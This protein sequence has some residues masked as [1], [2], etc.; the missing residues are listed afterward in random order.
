MAAWAWEGAAWFILL[1]VLAAA[2]AQGNSFSTTPRECVGY[3]SLLGLA[4]C[5]AYLGI[6]DAIEDAR[7]D[8][9]QD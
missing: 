2:V 5:C 9:K 4:V 3:G 6:D 8:V 1:S 7:G